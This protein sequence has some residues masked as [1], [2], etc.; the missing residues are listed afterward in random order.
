MA[1]V[2]PEKQR[3]ES[4][5]EAMII[6]VYEIQSPVEAQTMLELGVDHIGSVIVS[7]ERWKDPQIK[8]VVD[9]VG[10]SGRKSSLIPLFTDESAIARCVDYYHPH[11]LHFC[12]TLAIPGETSTAAQ[13]DIEGIRRCQA[14]L[15]QRFPQVEMMRSIPVACNG[16]SHQLASIELAR[17]F[18]PCSDWLL[19]DTFLTDQPENHQPVQGYVGIT[20]RTC[21]WALARRLVEAVRIPVI[22]AGG[23]GPAN[24]YDAV[25]A[26]RPAGIDSCTNTNA[27]DEHGQRIR[28]QKDAGK[29]EAMISQA[30]KAQ[31]SP[32]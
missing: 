25:Q 18:E 27:I 17:Y 28:F 16:N 29:V 24:A 1:G 2:A 7:Q 32:A 13:I 30:R 31:Q 19:I 11:I 9:R 21:D 3:P 5:K 22:L 10:A 15:K 23:I 26:V 14:S 4:K 12:E 6:Q 20:G 8:A